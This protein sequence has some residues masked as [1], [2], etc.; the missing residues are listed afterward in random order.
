MLS[1]HKGIKLDIKNKIVS[2]K[3]PTYLKT[4]QFTSKNNPCVK[5]KFAKEIRKYFDLNENKNMIYKNMW[6]VAKV[7]FREKFITLKTI[8][9]K[10]CKFTID[11]FN[12]HLKELGKKERLNP[13]Q[14]KK[15]KAENK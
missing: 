15:I 9:T 1:G 6:G 3:S 4:K 2:G 7:M 11:D 5:E 8:I 13:K 12:F 10:V 14:R